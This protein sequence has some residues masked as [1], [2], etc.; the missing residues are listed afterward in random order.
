MVS[1]CEF[2]KKVEIPAPF[3][4]SIYMS[5]CVFQSSGK[6][7]DREPELDKAALT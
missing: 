5:Q 2:I 6:S 7:L 3:I 1:E 4:T